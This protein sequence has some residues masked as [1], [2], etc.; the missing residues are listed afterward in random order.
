MPNASFSAKKNL[1]ISCDKCALSA[2]CRPLSVSGTEVDMV[3]P[4]VIHHQFVNRGDFLFHKG[5]PF[6]SVIAV[7]QGSVKLSVKSA[8]IQ[9]Q[10][11]GFRLIGETV[12][13]SGMH[14]GNYLTDAVTLENCHICEIPYDTLDKYANLVPQLQREIRH[15]LSDE[16]ACRQQHSV[17][18]GKKTAEERLASFLLNLSHR[19]SQRGYSANS[20]VLAM[21]R[22]DI[23]NYLGLT[24]ETVSRLFNKFHEKGLL[25]TQR[26]YIQI[27]D[28][29]LL[30]TVAGMG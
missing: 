16:L 24:K 30:K 3:S 23:A 20:F 11:L 15:L 18:L 22:S 14:S 28:S 12:G 29:G 21:T 4:I 17:S 8:Q 26:K 19:Y 25:F 7:V 27:T 9:E 10:I 6:R 5:E 1:P 2:L 13:L